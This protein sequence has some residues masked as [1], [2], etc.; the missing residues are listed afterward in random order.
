MA[1][2]VLDPEKEYRPRREFWRGAREAAPVTLGVLPYA[3]VLGAQAAQ[4]G[5]NLAEVPLMTGLNFAGGSEFAAVKLWSFPP[6]I[7]LI[8]AVTFLVNSRHIMMGATLAPLLRHMPKSRVLPALFLMTDESWALSYADAGKRSKTGAISAFSLP[9]YMGASLELYVV[10]LCCT[11]LGAA[12]GPVFGNVE[13]YG[14]DMAFPAVFLVLL[15]GM[16][17]G[18]RAARPWLASL[19]T[20]AVVY[21]LLPGAWYV[22]AGTVAGLLVAFF[23]G[24][25]ND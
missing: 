15:R 4:A 19:L 14:F 10:W 24:G 18:V 22:P 12:L 8:A 16:W 13:A 17:R 11:T 7:L 6:N 21:L 5:L 20:A 9:Y 23:M 25:N 2:S 1:L 3:L